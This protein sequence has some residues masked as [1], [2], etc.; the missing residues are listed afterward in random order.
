MLWEHLFSLGKATD[1]ILKVPVVPGSF[2]GKMATARSQ[3]A[4][5]KVEAQARLGMMEHLISVQLGVLRRLLAE[6]ATHDRVCSAKYVLDR[7]VL[8]AT[9]WLAGMRRRVGYGE[10]EAG[11][12][13]LEDVRRVGH[14]VLADSRQRGEEQQRRQAQVRA[15]AAARRVASRQYREEQAA[16]RAAAAARRLARQEAERQRLA[17][18]E[19]AMIAREARVEAR[20]RGAASPRR[21][22]SSPRGPPAGVRPRRPRKQPAP[23]RHQ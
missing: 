22:G 12:E 15:Q 7:H 17:A 20:N 4:K 19:R 16:A 10:A 23:R 13:R 11:M 9:E 5:M 21:G 3:S 14:R 8:S 6:G 18:L 1:H 2:S